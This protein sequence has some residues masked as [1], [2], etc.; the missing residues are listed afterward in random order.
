MNLGVS[1]WQIATMMWLLIVAPAKAQQDA[2]ATSQPQAPTPSQ[3]ATEQPTT[4]QS[5]NSQQDSRQIEGA[6]WFDRMQQALRALNFDAHFVHA[7]GDRIEPYRWVHGV[8]DNGTEIELLAGMN[9]PEYRALR[10]NNHVS[11]YHSL[12]TPYSMRTSVLSGPVPAGFF[13]PFQNISNAY[14]VV[15]VGGGRVMDRPAQHIRVVSRD[16]Q[17]YG[18]SIWVDRG[19]GMLL[20]SATVSLEG[21]VLEQVQLTSLFVNDEMSENLRELKS[22]ARPPL[23]DDHSNREPVRGAWAL[24]WLPQ[25]FE[26]VRSNSHRM[27]VTGQQAD[28]FLYS[29]G[30]AKF[31]LYI[32]ARGQ[33]TPSVQIEGADSLYSA[34]LND[35]QVTIVGSLPLATI[36][37]IAQSLRPATP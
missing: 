25:G 12:A 32:S 8:S 11:Y 30:L 23:I 4:S 31:S 19:T 35:Y 16:R 24:N 18:Y 15:S 21:D 5:T 22:I 13:Q 14:H 2:V 36:E 1:W 7:R 33:D 27:A 34:Q 6:Q 10:H 9:G 17:R 20:R 29:D 28:Y 37:R 26:L 3:Q